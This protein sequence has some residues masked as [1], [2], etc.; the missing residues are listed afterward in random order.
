MSNENKFGPWH[1]IK[2]EGSWQVV[3]R[4]GIPVA[5]PF[6]MV[7]DKEIVC[8]LIAAAPDMLAT[9]KEISK[10]INSTYGVEG[11]VAGVASS[12]EKTGIDKMVRDVISKAEGVPV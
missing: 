1:V 11:H 7:T 12:W 10:L 6:H 2:H 4:I 3:S 5:A 9:L 8:C